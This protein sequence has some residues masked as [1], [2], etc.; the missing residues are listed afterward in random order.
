MLDA[1]LLLIH[2]F[3][4]SPAT[5]DP[6][7]AQLSLEPDLA[8]LRI[9]AFGYESPKL[10]RW[11]LSPSRFPDYNDIAQSLPAYLA[12]QA[13]GEAP[14]VIV[15]HSQGGLILQR[16]LAWMLTEGRGRQ[17][18]RIKAIVMLSCPNEGSEYLASI[19]AVTGFDRHPQVGQLDAL[20]LEAG[21]ARRVVLRQIVHA[22]AQDDRQC[23]IPFYVYSGRTD[24]VVLRQSAQS[25]FP[26]AEVLPGDHF[27]ILDPGSP[28]SL[29]L[30]TI[31]R[32]ILNAIAEPDTERGQAAPPPETAAG[33]LAS[34]AIDLS[35]LQVMQ[36]HFSG[37]ADIRFSIANLTDHPQKVAVLLLRVAARREI[38][39]VR[40]KKA[41]AM[42]Q[43]FRLS[44]RIDERESQDLFA[45]LD[46]QEVLEPGAS[47]FFK[48]KLAAAEG[49]GYLCCLVAEFHDLKTGV[50]AE[51]SSPSFDVLYPIRTLEVLRTRQAR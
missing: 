2:G 27:T 23:P 36:E 21:Q 22:R 11:P 10:P 48:L 25:A 40:L 24:N 15:T 49:M 5:W 7:T 37:Y 38:D 4:S 17:L 47:D 19:R 34:G 26:F 33:S 51:V 32:H 1:D 12:A 42:M 14:I 29:T 16:F 41:G 31:K 45:D 39:M 9:H 46:G 30:P 18:A 3:W 44:A 28:G 13:P 6:L 20:G 8:G 35:R 50:C 43:E